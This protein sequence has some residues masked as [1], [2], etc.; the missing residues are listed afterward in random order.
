MTEYILS[1]SLERA[2]AIALQLDKPLLLCGEPGTGKTTLAKHLALAYSKVSPGD[3]APF[4]PRPLTFNTKTTSVASDLFY[5]YDALE[6]LRDAYG[7][8]RKP[9]GEYVELKALGKAILFKNGGGADSNDPILSIRDFKKPGQI[10]VVP[11][12]TLV[13]IDE[14]DKAPRDFP[15]DILNEIEKKHFEI[16]ELNV[17]VEAAVNNARILIIMTSNNEKNLP[18]AFLRRCIFHYI[19]FP[20]ELQMGRIIK[21]H[22]NFKNDKTNIEGLIKTFNRLR[23][24]AEIKKPATAEFIDW[25]RVL[26]RHSLVEAAQKPLHELDPQTAAELDQTLGVLFK[27]SNDISKAREALKYS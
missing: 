1:S 18:D 17:E 26:E 19:D 16:R 24:T 3:Y 8:V 6:R 12:S 7:N 14:I 9:V 11:T 2:I 10:P 25:L 4:Y 5:S 21:A 22:V 23:K 27:N 15:N 20:D 13:L